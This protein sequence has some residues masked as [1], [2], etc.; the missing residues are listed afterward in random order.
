[1][2]GHLSSEVSTLQAVPQYTSVRVPPDW[3][4]HC[5]SAN[6]ADMVRKDWLINLKIQVMSFS[7]L[8]SSGLD[9]SGSTEVQL[10]EPI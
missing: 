4:F 9:G 1:M 10:W 7:V 6:V 3:L 5:F 2:V 8:S